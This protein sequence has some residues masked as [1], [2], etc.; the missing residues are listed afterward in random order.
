MAKISRMQEGQILYFVR[1]EK[2]GNTT[3]SHGA[4]F[5]VKV[6][7]IAPD[8]TFVIAAVNMC[9]TRKYRQRDCDKWRV[10]KPRPKGKIMG[11]TEY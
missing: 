2:M 9:A 3:M 7:E 6:F 10:T 11:R 8:H 5:S 4:L 1:R